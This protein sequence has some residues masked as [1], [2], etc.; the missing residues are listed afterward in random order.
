MRT[1]LI[2]ALSLTVL[3]LMAVPALSQT[4]GNVNGYGVIDL[5]DLSNLIAY[6]GSNA[7]I[8]SPANADMDGRLGITVSDATKLM[9]Y[10][11]GTT[12]TFDCNPTLNY[13]LTLSTDDTLFFPTMAG[14]PDGIDSVALPVTTCLG[15]GAYGLYIPFLPIGPTGNSV[16]HLSSVSIVSDDGFSSS[17]QVGDTSTL[18]ALYKPNKPSPG[19]RHVTFTLNYVRSTPG[20][21]NIAPMPVNRSARWVPSFERGFDLFLPRVIY[22]DYVLPPETLKVSPINLA[23][24]AMAGKVAKDSFLVSFSSTG[25][26]IS[27]SLT[28]SSPWIVLKD[29]PGA[30]MTTPAS[31]WVKA[32]ATALAMGS[33]NG[34]IDI[35]PVKVGTP[36]VNS[37]VAVS[38]EVTKPILYPP[39]DLN[40]DGI[41]NLADLSR[42]VSYLTGGGATLLDC[43]H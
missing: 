9:A 13:S 4:C 21:G 42:F 7:P 20:V 1:F 3:L 37:S 22:K 26:P 33:Y 2:V 15:D 16:F 30:P 17:P 34:T 43:N 6:L 40:C 38:F 12:M 32:D 8:S 10:L 41:A 5:S 39:G 27:F 18:I 36:M 11:F 14:V 24:T 28:P 29:L 25:V 31:I 23:Y 35:T 19:G